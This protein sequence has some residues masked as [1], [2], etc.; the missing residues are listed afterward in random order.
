MTDQRTL[1]AKKIKL[2]DAE[3][4]ARDGFRRRMTEPLCMVHFTPTPEQIQ[5][6]NTQYADLYSLIRK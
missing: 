1:K 3:K 2:S 4:V 6:W 5:K